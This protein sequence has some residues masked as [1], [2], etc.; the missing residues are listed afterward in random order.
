LL[1]DELGY[2]SMK[3]EQ[4]SVFFKLIEMRYATKSTIITSNLAYEDWYQL[5]K[6][7]QLVKALL[8]RLRHITA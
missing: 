3:S 1:I 7:E 5:F 6:R 8:N 4:V 2:L